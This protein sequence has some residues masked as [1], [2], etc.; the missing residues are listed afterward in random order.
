MTQTSA[1]STTSVRMIN[2]PYHNFSTSYFLVL[3]SQKRARSDAH[4]YSMP[5][6]GLTYILTPDTVQGT[7]CM[8]SAKAPKFLDIPTTKQEL[9]GVLSP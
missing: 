7:F 4:K 6:P 1:S 3:V 9:Y 5:S 2:K 8:Q